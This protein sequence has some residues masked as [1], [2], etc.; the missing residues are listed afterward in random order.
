MVK[1]SA[2]LERQDSPGVGECIHL[3]P[4]AI[5]QHLRAVVYCVYRPYPQ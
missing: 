4:D 2:F 5:A 3:D 1:N